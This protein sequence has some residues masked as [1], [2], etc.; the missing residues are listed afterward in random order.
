[1]KIERIERPHSN[2]YISVKTKQ[3]IYSINEDFKI[4][5]L[6]ISTNLLH[7]DIFLPIYFMLEITTL[8]NKVLALFYRSSIATR[9]FMR[10]SMS[11]L[12]L[13]VK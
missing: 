10:E 13:M 4:Q 5:S 2:Q 9:N 8:G 11:R 12:T 3:K 7:N 1:M 6:F